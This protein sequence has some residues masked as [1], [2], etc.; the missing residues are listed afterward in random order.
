MER[1]DRSSQ[2]QDQIQDIKPQDRK[3]YIWY[4]DAN[5]T[6]LMYHESVETMAFQKK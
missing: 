5:L 4:S 3:I 2:V 1:C 6:N